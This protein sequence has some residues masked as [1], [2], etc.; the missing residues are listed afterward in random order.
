MM[1]PTFDNADRTLLAT[2]QRNAQV[3]LD[4]LADETGL[5]VATVQRRLTQLRRSGVIAGTVAVLDPAALGQAMTFVDSVELERERPD[6]IDGFARTACAEPQ[7][8]QC[9]YVTGEGDFVLICVALDMA[10]FEALTRR[11]FFD[12]PN[13]RRFRTSVVMTSYKRTLDVPTDRPNVY[14]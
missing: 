5:S 12:Q 9:H 8:Q 6:Q 13:V 10:D 14:G 7:V 11:L 1:M 2:L 3:K 4:Q